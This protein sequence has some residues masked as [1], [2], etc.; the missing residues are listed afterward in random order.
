MSLHSKR[1]RR[2]RHLDEVAN[3]LVQ[4]LRRL[5]VSLKEPVHILSSSP[6]PPL[7]PS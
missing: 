4:V 1:L 2:Q 7:K 5:T 3:G 6:D